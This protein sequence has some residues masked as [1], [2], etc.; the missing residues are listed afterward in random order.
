M[1]GG[2]AHGKAAGTAP[3]IIT[4]AGRTITMSLAFI[5]T[6]ILNGEHTIAT[7]IGRGIDGIMSEFPDNGSRITGK[8][9][10]PIGIGKGI[11]P[12][13]WSI[14]SPDRNMSSE[15]LENN[16]K[17]ATINDLK[18]NNISNSCINKNA[19]N[20][21]PGN[22]LERSKNENDNRMRP[23]T[24]K[25]NSCTSKNANNLRSKNHLE[26]SENENDNRMH[27]NTSNRVKSKTNTVGL[28][29]RDTQ[30]PIQKMLG[31]MG[32]SEIEPIK[33]RSTRI[34]FA[35]PEN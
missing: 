11:E 20:R 13:M 22:S 7:E 27:T 19:N 10:I 29:N 30:S 3:A 16:G 6:S 9:G 23:N 32:M 26:K 25:R 24:S 28:M 2:G 17:S 34:P 21:R 31:G 8:N 12:G 35:L 33:K 14:I 1:G 18:S 4:V 5:M 15:Q